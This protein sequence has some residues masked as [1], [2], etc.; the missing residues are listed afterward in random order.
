MNPWLTALV[1]FLPA[2][3]ANAT[4][5]LANKIPLLKSWN[6]PIDFG[7]SRHGKRLLGNNKTWRGMLSASLAAGITALL[8]SPIVDYDRSLVVTFGF[9]FLMG[10]GALFGDAVESFIKRQRGIA[11]GKSWFPF[12]QIDYIIGGLVFLAPVAHL[13][14]GE[15]ALI[16]IVYFALHLLTAYAAYLLGLKDR[17]I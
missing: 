16:F 5:V 14:S 8:L 17:P 6:T 13:S 15:M 11:A 2:G 9:G 7:A 3:V 10:F 1:F 12:D 4:P